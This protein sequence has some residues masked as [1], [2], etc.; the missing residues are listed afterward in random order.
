MKYD[1]KQNKKSRAYTFAEKLTIL[2]Q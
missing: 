1:S 2:E